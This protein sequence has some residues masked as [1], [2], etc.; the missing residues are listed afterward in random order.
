LIQPFSRGKWPRSK[1][2]WAEHRSDRSEDGDFFLGG[3]SPLSRLA[4]I[5]LLLG[6]HKGWYGD[7]APEA[8]RGRAKT[9]HPDASA[10]LVGTVGRSRPVEKSLGTPACYRT[11]NILPMNDFFLA[12]PTV[13]PMY[14]VD[15]LA[16][17]YGPSGLCNDVTR[18][19][20]IVWLTA[21][22][23][24]EVAMFVALSR[25]DLIQLRRVGLG[26]PQ[27]AVATRALEATRP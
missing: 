21:G 27:A 5:G 11:K 24:R 20:W 25:D 6:I 23:E 12:Q 15:A 16:R 2:F 1:I 13:C 14:R 3:S 8:D 9:G 26:L 7:P 4:Q 22:S 17:A 19:F 18:P 10:A